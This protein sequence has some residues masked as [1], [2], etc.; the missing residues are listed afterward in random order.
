[1]SNTLIIYCHPYEKS[2]NHAIVESV[3]NNL[4][5]HHTDWTMIDLYKEAFNPTYNEE[6]LRL[7][8]DGKSHDPHVLK[9]L[10]DLQKADKLIF[11]TPIWWN[12]IPGMLK[13]FIDKVMKEGP[14]LS[15]T[16]TKTGVKGNLTNI[17]QAYV[18][19]TSTSPTFY[20]RFFC[21]NGINRIFIR[22]TLRQL[23]IKKSKW[24]NFGGISTS[25]NSKR[26]AYLDQLT[27]INF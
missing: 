1:M 14:G 6:E 18:L 10:E 13:G 7:F 19:T 9:Y 23:G 16:V 25:K 27:K 24:V 3:I 20:F 17:K 4:E 26:T 8:H 21:G 2:F 22:Q 12:S 5:L 11:V 15:H